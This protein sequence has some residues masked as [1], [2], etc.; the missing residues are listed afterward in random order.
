VVVESNLII[1]TGL[2]VTRHGGV[3]R[4]QKPSTTSARVW[5]RRRSVAF[6]TA[7]IAS[8]ACSRRWDRTIHPP[9]WPTTLDGPYRRSA[10]LLSW[11]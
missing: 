9:G 8:A 5:R 2:G 4:A 7:T 3:R 11:R 10:H 1:G 6:P